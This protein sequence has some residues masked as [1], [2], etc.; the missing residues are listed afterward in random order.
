MQRNRELH[1]FLLHKAE[2]LTEQ[3][4]ESL[5]KSDPRGVYASKD[6]KVIE[7]LKGQN[8]EF[9]QHLCK[10]F[11][12]PMDQFLEEFDDWVM[13]IASDPEHLSTPTY[14]IMRE[15]LRVRDQYL[16]FV[17]E[18]IAV[19]DHA[20]TQEQIDR[21]KEVLIKAFDIVTMRV[22]EEKSNQLDTRIDKQQKTINELSS[23]LIDLSNGR[24]LLPLV[25]DI[26][27]SRASAIMDNTLKG[28]TDKGIDQLFIDLSG[29]YL[30]DTMVAH[31]IFQLISGLQLIG[32]S[33]TLSGIRPEIA[34][35]AVQLGIDFGQISITPTLAQAIDRDP[36]YTSKP[37]S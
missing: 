18:F 32:V 36:I 28:C 10:V 9:H 26:D 4:Y 6:P 12:Q 35:T 19:S 21:W 8:F 11:I 23:P 2:D 7:T 24:A 31:Q 22:V 25:G 20:Y 37:S 13:K 15:F 30:V 17:K 33:T 3:W 14:L 27:S 34:H 29:V 5:D 1:D 16:Y